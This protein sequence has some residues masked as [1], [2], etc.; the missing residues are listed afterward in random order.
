MIKEDGWQSLKSTQHTDAAFERS[1]G[2]VQQATLAP[3]AFVF[4]TLFQ[5]SKINR[6]HCCH[7]AGQKEPLDRKKGEKKYFTT[8]QMV[9]FT[10]DGVWFQESCPCQQVDEWYN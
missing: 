9:C 1:V 2:F 7:T 10:P 6:L 3:C 8:F 4:T 5:M